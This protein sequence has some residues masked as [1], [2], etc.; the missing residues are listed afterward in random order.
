MGVRKYIRPEELQEL[1]PIEVEWEDASWLPR[2]H[3]LEDAMTL[4]PSV[5]ATRGYFVNMDKGRLVMCQHYGRQQGV[6]LCGSI[7]S[8]PIQN[9]TAIMPRRESMREKLIRLKGVPRG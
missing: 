2:W 5:I 4:T 7:T 9:V 3:S 1:Q 6:M 8:I